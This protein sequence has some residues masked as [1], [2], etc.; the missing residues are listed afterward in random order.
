MCRGS[1]P[2]HANGVVKGAYCVDFGI[3]AGVP[4]HRPIVQPR[5]IAG[6]WLPWI[7]TLAVQPNLPGVISDWP[8][9][10]T[11]EAAMALPV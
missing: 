2:P 8:G 7:F 10:D 1:S 11:R 9:D 4:R 5:E 3:A 6:T